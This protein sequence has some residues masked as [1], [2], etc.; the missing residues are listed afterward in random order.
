M[1]KDMGRTVTKALRH[2][3]EMLGLT[4]DQA[5]YCPVDDLI[6]SLKVRGFRAD[7]Q[8]IEKLGENER[9]SFNEDHTKMR[10]D[11]GHSIGLHLCDMYSADSE[12]PE[13]LY[14]G[15][16]YESLEGIKE[17]GI[18]R[19]GVNGKKGRDHIFT[20]ELQAVALKKGSRH[21]KS[22]ALPIRAHDM[23]ENGYLFYHAK[24][25]IWLTDHI[26]AEYIRWE[27]IYG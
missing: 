18:I 24:N 10:A 1:K 20:T 22:V 4:L 3:P 26:P 7:V 17:K 11:Y 14:H 5:G 23:Y 27:M 13:I 8:A 16:A 6:E 15:T 9:F 2:N 21:G 12:P 19:L 25:D